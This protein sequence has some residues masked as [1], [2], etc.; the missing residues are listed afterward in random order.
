MTGP[1]RAGRLRAVSTRF[2]AFASTVALLLVACDIKTEDAA[3]GGGECNGAT[4]TDKQVCLF[5]E[6]TMDERCRVATQ[7]A[8]NETP[9]QCATGPGCLRATCG[10]LV[11]GCRDI[12]TSCSSDVTC[13]CQSIC[14]SAA[15]CKKVDGKNALC[16][17][18]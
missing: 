12:P 5:R 17:G 11:Q 14:G 7:C 15:A 13:A 2:L 1:A 8:S 4:C 16:A 3:D 10:P 18:S 9:T 6:C